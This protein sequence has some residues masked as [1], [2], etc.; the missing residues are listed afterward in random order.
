MICFSYNNSYV[1]DMFC[2]RYN[3][4]VS[5]ICNI[6]YSSCVFDMFGNYFCVGFYRQKEHIVDSLD[7]GSDK[8]C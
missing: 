5:D 7:V 6:R 3:S 1:F 2:F 8:V 4:Y